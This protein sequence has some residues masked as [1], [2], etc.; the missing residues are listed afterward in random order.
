[1]H[2]RSSSSSSSTTLTNREKWFR[3]HKRHARARTRT[4]GIR[5]TTSNTTMKRLT[6][7]C[8]NTTAP[9]QFPY[10]TRII[11]ILHILGTDDV[12]CPVNALMRGRC[13]GGLGRLGRCR[14]MHHQF[15]PSCI[16][17]WLCIMPRGLPVYVGAAL[18]DS[19]CYYDVAANVVVKAGNGR[20]KRL[21]L[22]RRKQSTCKSCMCVRVC[23][24]S[25]LCWS[26]VKPHARV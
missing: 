13:E 24:F 16:I 18:A 11:H 25:W 22:Q 7:A 1:M 3:K 14:K 2:G 4:R 19:A 23:V 9:T 6:L 20:R 5:Q 26:N 12:M 15:S 10:S 17:C 8:A 21:A